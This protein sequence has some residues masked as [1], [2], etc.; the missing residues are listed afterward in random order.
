MKEKIEKF[1]KEKFEEH[2]LDIK[3]WSYDFDNS[4]KQLGLCSSK[5]KKIFISQYNF[6]YYSEE[7]F[8][9][10]VL[11]EIAHA[12]NYIEGTEDG[13]GPN[14]KKICIR[15]GAEPIR[16]AETNNAI[17]QQKIDNKEYKWTYNCPKCEHIIGSHRRR[18]I[19]RSCGKCCSYWNPEYELIEKKVY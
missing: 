11:H 3:G 19:K 13:H 4:K 5:R 12:L 18:T 15:I 14:W 10:T 6:K 1:L 17:I 2:Q 8:K 7:K 9:N 16:C